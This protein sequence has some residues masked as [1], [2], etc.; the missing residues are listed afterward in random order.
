MLWQRVLTALVLIPL[1]VSGILY[2]DSK[3]LATLLAAFVL[4]AAHELGRLANRRHA[5]GLGVFV[6]AVAAAL[7]LG[8]AYLGPAHLES[9]Q[10]ILSIWWVLMTAALVA[11]RSELQRVDQP[12]PAILLLGGVV[13]VSAWLS[14]ISL[15][16]SGPRGPVLVLFLFVL[17]LI[18]IIL[19]LLLLLLLLLLL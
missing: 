16:A 13:L 15:H 19:I 2:L 14:I 3:V 4:L 5:T 10:W 6:L 7:W 1:V 17:I 11:R 8:W 18:L 9:V 12:R